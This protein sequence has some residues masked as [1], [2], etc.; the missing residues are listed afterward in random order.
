MTSN[1]G[2]E[3][4]QVAIQM[5]T[6]A[7]AFFDQAS[8][9]YRKVRNTLRFLLSNLTDF[10][11]STSNA[12]GT[13]VDLAKIEPTSIDALV[14]AEVYKV[15]VKVRAGYDNYRFRTWH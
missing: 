13:G 10:V 5:E 2:S 6:D 7:M 9:T 8:E 15:S 3:A 14:F 4:L 11:T 1:K 12:P